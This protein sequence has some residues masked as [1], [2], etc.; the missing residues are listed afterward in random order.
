MIKE[1]YISPETQQSMYEFFLKTSAPRLA[2]KK[3]EEQ[4][5]KELNQN[6]NQHPSMAVNGSK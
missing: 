2:K 6:E 4:K 5:Q 3:I 1:I